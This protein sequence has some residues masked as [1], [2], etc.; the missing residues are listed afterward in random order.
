MRKKE[1]Q[2]NSPQGSI[3]NGKIQNE[4][5]LDSNIKNMKYDKYTMQFRST[6][7]ETEVF[8]AVLHTSS[9]KYSIMIIRVIR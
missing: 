1:I 4:V 8:M 9:Q 3:K 7:H 6:A 5:L 2:N